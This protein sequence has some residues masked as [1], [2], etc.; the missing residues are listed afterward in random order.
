M[1]LCWKISITAFLCK[2]VFQS[3]GQDYNSCKI[4]MKPGSQS[5]TFASK[6]EVILIEQA[7]WRLS[8]SKVP[9]RPPLLDQMT[10]FGQRESAPAILGLYMGKFKQRARTV[11]SVPPQEAHLSG[12]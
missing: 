8:H 5:T 6:L 10:S 11:A 7:A 12:S 4:L 2:V 9:Q 3:R 1:R